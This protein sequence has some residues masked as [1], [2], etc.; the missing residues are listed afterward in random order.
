MG[1]ALSKLCDVLTYPV[2]EY[3]RRKTQEVYDEVFQ[4]EIDE[5]D[6]DFGSSSRLSR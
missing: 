2:K 4:E 1:N 3:N 6:S 5:L